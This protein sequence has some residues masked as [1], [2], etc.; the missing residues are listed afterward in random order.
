MAPKE[1]V[2]QFRSTG[3]CEGLPERDV[4]Q[5]TRCGP[6]DANDEQRFQIALVLKTIRDRVGGCAEYR[7]IRILTA[8]VAGAGKSF[9]IHVLTDLVRKLLGSAGVAMVYAPTGVAAFQVGGPAGH[10]LLQ[11]PT[12]K[13]AFGQLDS[14][15]GE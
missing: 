7:P 12:G 15:K 9:V 14:L 5:V 8:G 3:N 13:K 11:L 10:S 4:A 6:Y 1:R 2:S